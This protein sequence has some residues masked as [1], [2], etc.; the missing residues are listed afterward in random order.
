M[1]RQEEQERREYL[2]SL[3]RDQL[4][5]MLIAVLDHE[6]ELRLELDKLKGVIR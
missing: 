6:A 1:T 5:D 3:D 4:I 2:E